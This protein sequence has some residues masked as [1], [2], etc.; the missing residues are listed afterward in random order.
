VAILVPR[1]EINKEIKREKNDIKKER[2]KAKE[3]VKGRKAT[4]KQGTSMV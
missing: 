1:V 4:M 2:K 3:N